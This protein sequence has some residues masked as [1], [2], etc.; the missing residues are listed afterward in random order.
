MIVEDGTGLSTAQSYI[1]VA[2][3]DTYH[4]AHGNTTWTGVDALKEAA[5]VRATQALDARY[6]WPGFRLVSTQALDWP[7][8]DAYDV[9]GYILSDVPQGIKDAL[10]EMALLELVTPGELTESVEVSV[11]REKVGALETE[12]FERPRTSYPAVDNALRR[13][14]RR[15]GGI[16]IVRRA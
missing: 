8:Y 3:A 11:K 16:Q 7:R 6:D 9:D 13:I 14:L 12:Y 5:L 10:C 4:T 2:N 1:S 15:S